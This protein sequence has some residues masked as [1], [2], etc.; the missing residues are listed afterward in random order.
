MNVIVN[1][2][3]KDLF[4]F[5]ERF[6]SITTVKIYFIKYIFYYTNHNFLCIENFN[7]QYV[8]YSLSSI[9]KKV[10]PIYKKKSYFKNIQFKNNR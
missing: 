8:K 4:I 7:I 6:V 9:K 10:F 5:S 1:F 2:F 3:N